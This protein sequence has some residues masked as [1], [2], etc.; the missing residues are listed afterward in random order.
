MLFDNSVSILGNILCFNEK[1][2]IVKK[3]KNGD[4]FFIHGD[5]DIFKNLR[6]KKIIQ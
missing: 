2:K 3:N 1:D 6:M 5:S 4:K